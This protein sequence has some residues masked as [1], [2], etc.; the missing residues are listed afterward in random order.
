MTRILRTNGTAIL[1]DPALLPGV[2][3]DWFDPQWW[4]RRGRVA[5]ELGGRARAVAVRLDDDGQAVL[6]RY[7]RGG[8][9]R[10]FV[11]DRYAYTG[12]ERTRSFREWR[13][14]RALREARLPVPEPLAAYCQVSGPV[15]RAALLTRRVD[16]AADLADRAAQL[17]AEDWERLGSTIR[18]F[19]DAGLRHPDLN[20]GNLL[21]DESGRFW[22]LDFD[23]AR[24]LD[25]PAPA[26]AMITRLRRSLV[27]LGLPHDA[28]A[29]ERGA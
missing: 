10:R 3:P 12:L 9:M 13:L 2:E 18:R 6:R 14:M 24:L 11:R 26:A 7:H 8:W 29:L 23:R 22:M 27:K 1:H 15:Y 28:E 19:A 21:F 20:A 4:A 16:H 5:D 25:E 17:G